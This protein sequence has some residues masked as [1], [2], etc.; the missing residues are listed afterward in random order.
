[1]STI[2]GATI[3]QINRPPFP[4]IIV[5]CPARFN[6]VLDRW[7]SKGAV[8]GE[9]GLTG[10]WARDALYSRSLTI[11]GGTSEV[12]KNLLA[13]RILGLPRENA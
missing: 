1:M 6:A 10:A 13:E 2:F 11:A 8:L 12:N 4:R 9:A 3:E 7:G 5:V